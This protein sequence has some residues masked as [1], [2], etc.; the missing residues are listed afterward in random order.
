MFRQFVLRRIYYFV[1]TL[2]VR[3]YVNY[4]LALVLRHFRRASNK[5]L[6]FTVTETIRRKKNVFSYGSVDSF[7]HR[8]KLTLTLYVYVYIIINAF[9]TFPIGILIRY[10]LLIFL[11]FKSRTA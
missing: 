8:V 9:G 4:Y 1:F 3:L 5:A 11:A 7:H 10:E 2:T 6:S